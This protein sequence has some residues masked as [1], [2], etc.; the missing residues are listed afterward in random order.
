MIKS[1][2]KKRN[3]LFEELKKTAKISI[4]KNRVYFKIP[5]DIALREDI[6][7]GLYRLLSILYST[8]FE[9]GYIRY[10]TATLS[11]LMGGKSKGSITRLIK[12]GRELGVF[13]TRNN[14]RCLYFTLLDEPFLRASKK[15][16]K[17]YQKKLKDPLWQKKR[18]K[19]LER[20]NWQC[21][22]CGN[23]TKT[24]TVHHIKYHDDL[25]PWEYEDD[26]L[27]TLCKN[28]HHDI[29]KEDDND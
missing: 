17:D 5:R 21:K 26:E 10:K 18:L 1:A 29:H 13:E 8:N 27:V 12:I 16:K 4:P 24:L 20:D 25:E 19:I 28:C 6:S 23:K 3:N 7:D 14:G 11:K 9:D 15:S 2:S 22:L